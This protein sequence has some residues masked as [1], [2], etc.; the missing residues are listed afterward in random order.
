MLT[1]FFE[2]TN[3]SFGND[4]PYN[5]NI[6]ENC[7]N[8]SFEVKVLNQYNTFDYLHSSNAKRSLRSSTYPY[9]HY[10]LID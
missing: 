2:Y 10:D 4:F 9:P 3:W 8:V 7:R 6:D 5:S 1:F